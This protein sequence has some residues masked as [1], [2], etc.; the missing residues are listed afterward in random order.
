[1]SNE[2]LCS[3]L[4]FSYKKKIV[5]N[6]FN[7]N[8][9]AGTLNFWTGPSGSGKSTLAKIICGHCLPESGAITILN[10]VNPKPS[11]NRLYIGHENDLFFWQTLRQHFE[12]LKNNSILKSNMNYNTIEDF[13]KKLQ[14][15]HLLNKFPSQISMGEIRRFQILR[16]IV[17][18][19]DLIIFD[20]TFSALDLNL[21]DQILIFLQDFWKKNGSTVVIISHEKA[22]SFNINFDRILKFPV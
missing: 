14:I 11:L 3:N 19:P 17:I 15:E 12:L 16:S 6:K 2:F 13:A 4:S 8:L 20:E 1:M 5:F 7:L 10:K 21:K 18:S 22:E 9:D